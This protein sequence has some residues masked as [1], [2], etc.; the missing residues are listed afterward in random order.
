L[1]TRLW[2]VDLQS[3]RVI[4]FAERG[5]HGH[6]WRNLLSVHI[7][8][9]MPTTDLSLISNTLLEALKQLL[10]AEKGSFR[11]IAVDAGG[12]IVDYALPQTTS[13]E[14]V[15]QAPER[16]FQRVL[17]TPRGCFT[18][19][20]TTRDVDMSEANRNAVVQEL[21]ALKAPVS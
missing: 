10:A 18:V 20:F 11:L 14:G 5:Q 2:Q 21:K 16:A 1:L 13:P 7:N 3:Y 6:D 8:I 12:Y 17:V 4:E 15:V 9:E 19:T